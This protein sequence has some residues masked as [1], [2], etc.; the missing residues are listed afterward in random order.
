M[1]PTVLQHFAALLA[2][3][4]FLSA[5]KTQAT[6][7]TAAAT[8]APQVEAVEES[9]SGDAVEELMRQM[10]LRQKVGQLFMVRPDAL[11]LTLEQ[12]TIDDEKA[13][14]VTYLSDAMRQTLE[15]Y[16]VGGICQF[17]KNI[18]DPQQITTFNASLQE[19]SAVPLLIAVDEEGG[20]VARLANHPGFE[21]P[22]YES[23][24]AVGATGNPENARQMGCTIGSYLK[25]YGFTMD[26]AP[27]ADVWTNPGNTVIGTRAFSQ[28]ASM[29]AAMADSMAR[30]LR[31]AGI[32]PTFKH[33]PGHGNT[34]EDS[35]S[36]LAYT[37]RTKEEMTQCEFLPFLSSSGG[38]SEEGFRA[39]M[40]GHIAA[41]ELGTG[42]TPASLSW[43]M[44]TKLLREELLENEDVLVITDSL[45]MGAITEQYTPGQAAVEAVLAGNDMILMPDGLAE[46]F[47]AVL[48]AVEDGTISEERLD[49]SVARILRFKQQYAGLQTAAG[50]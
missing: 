1:K 30:G 7:Q 33:F 25:S 50:Q 43:Q 3:P 18:T 8:P 45:A 28:D 17:G 35:H 31:E 9:T 42:E 12:E 14:G 15:E 44:V 11:D 29:A 6:A 32:L 37:Y 38:G 26:F 27:V 40:V 20:S 34:A 16:P 49:E 36:G 48:A 19:A 46:A 22:Q 2:V 4:L 24:A 23:T 47:E 39:V 10:T 13:G 5:C 41:P 21:L